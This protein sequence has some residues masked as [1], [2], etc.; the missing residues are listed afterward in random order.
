MTQSEALEKFGANVV[1]DIAANQAQLGMVASGKSLRSLAYKVAGNSVTVVGLRYFEFQEYGSG[2]HKG[3]V[4]GWFVRVIAEWARVKGLTIPA[5][6]VAYKIWK[7]GT[8]IYRKR[9]KPLGIEQIVATNAANL[10]D[11]IGR[12]YSQTLTSEIL[13]NL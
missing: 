11:D 9:A 8:R 5:F 6:P 10:A 2:P 7:D 3:K 12:A 4:P 1:R 13:R